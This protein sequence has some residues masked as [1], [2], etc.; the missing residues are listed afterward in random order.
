M[1]PDLSGLLYPSSWPERKATALVEFFQ[2]FI[3]RSKASASLCP[4][5]SRDATSSN[6]PFI[7]RVV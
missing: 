1:R 2:D 4:S 5:P 3:F 6:Y 7:R